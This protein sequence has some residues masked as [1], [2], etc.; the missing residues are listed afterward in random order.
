MSTA[1]T[2]VRA[3]IDPETKT[4]AA[5]ALEAD[6]LSISEAI[7]LFIQRIATEQKLPFDLTMPNAATREAIAQL[8]AGEG[9]SYASIADLMDDL[10]AVD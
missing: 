4:L 7:R 9:D 5:R 8:Q 6:G 10:H 2:T 1:D 3:R